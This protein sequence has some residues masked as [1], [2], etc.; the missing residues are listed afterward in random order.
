MTDH[1]EAIT[2]SGLYDRLD[3]FHV[4]FV[5]TPENVAAVRCTLDVLAPGYEVCA[6]VRSGWEQETLHPLW[7][8][9]HDHGGYVA[10]AHTKGAANYDPINDPWRRS[11]TWHC[12]VDWEKPVAALDQGRSVAGCHWIAGG[13][14]S[15]PGY[16]TGGMF[17]GNFWWARCELAA[18]NVAPGRLSR[19]EAEHWLGQLSEVTPLTADTIC[20]LNPNPIAPHHL[21]SEW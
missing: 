9:C 14:S 20:D 18:Q 1:C 21:R 2:R 7:E 12:F 11:M 6:D 15:V 5:G 4:G 13:P 3:S 16:G 19:Y 17:G 8:H 10:Y